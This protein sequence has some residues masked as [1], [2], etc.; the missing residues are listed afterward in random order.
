MR[1]AF[2]DPGHAALARADALDEENQRLRAD[3]EAARAALALQNDVARVLSPQR[4]FVRAMILAAT[5]V[6]ALPACWNLGMG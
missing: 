5:V 4:A 2:R 6:A 1:Q 3:L